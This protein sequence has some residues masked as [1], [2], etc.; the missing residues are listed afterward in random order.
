[1]CARTRVLVCVWSRTD[2]VKIWHCLG[3]SG[4]GIAASQQSSTETR[5]SPHNQMALGLQQQD[6]HALPAHC[7]YSPG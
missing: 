6:P 7:H 3:I 2:I 4:T 5:N 1:M